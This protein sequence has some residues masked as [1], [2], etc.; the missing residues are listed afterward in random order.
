MNNELNIK[1]AG[2]NKTIK[3]LHIFAPNYTSRFGGQN[4]FWKYGFSHWDKQAVEHFVLDYE[5]NRLI[6]AKEAFNFQYTGTQK[7]L[8]KWKR[9]SWVVTLFKNLIKY[10]NSYDVLH[11]HVLWWGTILLAPWAKWMRIPALYESILLGDD[12]PGGISTETLGNLKIKFIKKYKAILAISEFL[13]KDY[14]ECGFPE[15]QVFT[16]EN[17]VDMDTFY[18]VNSVEEKIQLRQKHQLPQ[19]ANVLLFVGSVVQRKGVDLLVRA[20]IDAFSSCPDLYLLI[21]GPRNKNENPSLDEGFVNDLHQL[22]DQNKLSA[23]VSFRGLIQDRRDLA[24]I[25]RASD[26]FVFP[27][28]NEG[29]GNVILEALASKLPVIVSRLPVLE[30]IIQHEQTGLFVPMN[31][32]D[33]VRDAI[34]RLCNTPFLAKSISCEAFNYMEKNHGFFVWQDDLTNIYTHLLTPEL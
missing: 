6:G 13:A 11:V 28:R 26:L 18:P 29:L 4:I 14:R 22:L 30:K 27:S 33:A 31:D 16:L 12:T 8:S 17:C 9:A 1:S 3:I 21:V 10:K 7:L 20:F 24:E 5:N 19:N 2:V 32:V 34:V 15:R 25:Y 23:R